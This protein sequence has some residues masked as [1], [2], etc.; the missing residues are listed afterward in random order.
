MRMTNEVSAQAPLQRAAPTA[1]KVVLRGL[2]FYYG[3][4]HA[5]KDVDLSLYEG[6][7]TAFIGPS[8]SGCSTACTTSIP[9]SAPK[10]R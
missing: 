8:G 3:K 4:V 10:A 5:L 1:E 2:N 9:A 6:Q 7:V